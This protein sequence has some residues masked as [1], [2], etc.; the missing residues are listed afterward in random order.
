MLK[1]TA[2]VGPKDLHHAQLLS[3]LMTFGITIK[4]APQSKEAETP[5]LLKVT[6]DAGA[7]PV[8]GNTGWFTIKAWKIHFHTEI[9][10]SPQTQG[11]P[12]SRVSFECDSGL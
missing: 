5:T 2:K 7:Q 10:C 6:V 12:K 3:C 1:V 9:L 8:D 11:L 4:S